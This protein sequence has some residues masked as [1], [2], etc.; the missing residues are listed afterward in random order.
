MATN[1]S[2]NSQTPVQVAKG[3]TGNSSST[4]Y[5]VLCGGTTTTAALQS[6]ASVGT[7]GQVLTSNGAGALPTF[8]TP[9]TVG[10]TWV[11]V[12]SNTSMLPN[13]G[14]ICNASGGAFNL[15]LPA[16][17]TLG[18]VYVV[19]LANSGGNEVTIEYN[20]SQFIQF[21]ASATTT[22]SGSLVTTSI[23]DTVYLVYGGSNQFIAISIV[24]NI[25]VN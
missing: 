3:G 20:S 21:G 15:T 6:V 12:S 19:T 18:D 7:T 13:H 5:A 23:G 2:W 16:S 9:S 14:Y 11:G 22:S 24:G 17:P 10:I 8:Q 4:A 1:N 25:T